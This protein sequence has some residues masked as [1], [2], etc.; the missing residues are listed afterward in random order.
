MEKSTRKNILLGLFVLVGMALFIAGIFLI[1]SKNEMFDKTFSLTTR[2]TN[3]TGL[4]SGSNVRFNGV[5]VGIVKLVSI[6]SDTLVEVSMQ[7]EESKRRYIT[8][9]AVA[10]IASDGLM[11]DKIVN[12]FTTSGDGRPVGNNDTM[13]SHNPLVTDQV[14]QT[15]NA[16]NENVREISANLKTVTADLASGHGAIQALYKDSTIALELQESVMDLRK[17]MQKAQ[18]AGTALQQITSGIQNGGGL[19]AR[20]INDTSL[21]MD[22]V[23]TMNKLR[24]TSV[25]LTKASDQVTGIVSH[26]NTGQGALGMLLTDTTFSGDLRQSMQNLKSASIKLDQDMEAMKHNFLT[27]KYFKKLSKKK[28]KQ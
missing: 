20:L 9:N 2:F 27:R 22:L 7:I 1:G 11:G 19:A 6:V 21:S 16:T 4:K 13:K 3:A 25:Q 12:I 10:T 14:L 8:S 15:L 28:K 17:T 24:E 18:Q 23:H 5:K 26:I